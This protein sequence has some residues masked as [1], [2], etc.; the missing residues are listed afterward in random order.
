MRTTEDNNDMRLLLI[1]TSTMIK[2]YA[3]LLSEQGEAR[4]QQGSCPANFLHRYTFLM[5]L[6][7]AAR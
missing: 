7:L 1:V 6:K 2:L 5:R 3:C 4:I